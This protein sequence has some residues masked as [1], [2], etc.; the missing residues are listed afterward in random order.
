MDEF[1]EKFQTD[2]DP[3]PK[4]P[5]F[6]RDKILQVFGNML[7]CASFDTV[8]PSNI[9]SIKMNILQHKFLILSFKGNLTFWWANG[10]PPTHTRL[11]EE[12]LY[13]CPVLWITLP[14][15][16]FIV[17]LLLATFMWEV[18][19]VRIWARERGN[20]QGCN[21]KG[22]MSYT[23]DWQKKIKFRLEYVSKVLRSELYNTGIIPKM[24]ELSWNIPHWKE[25]HL[26]CFKL[27]NRFWCG[28]L[29]STQWTDVTNKTQFC[30]VMEGQGWVK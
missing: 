22:W 1:S 21:N 20:T 28:P 6:W 16:M 25:I 30:E 8:S 12:K 27:W 5:Y 15:Y 19:P 23:V 10:P 17:H 11:I 4:P 18:S 29:V 24:L 3:S 9:V 13:L 14:A 2:L 26:V 7:T